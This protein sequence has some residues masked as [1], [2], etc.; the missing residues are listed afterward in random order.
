MYDNEIRA[1]QNG[2]DMTSKAIWNQCKLRLN[3]HISFIDQL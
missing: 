1:D 2:I 3:F